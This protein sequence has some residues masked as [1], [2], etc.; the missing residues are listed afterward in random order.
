MLINFHTPSLPPRVTT[1]FGERKG[2]AVQPV[3]NQSLR[4]NH[5][6]NLS[7]HRR[8]GNKHIRHNK[9][10]RHTRPNPRITVRHPTRIIP[11][12][13]PGITTI[14]RNLSLTKNFK[15]LRRNRIDTPSFD[16]HRLVLFSLLFSY[17][18][19]ACLFLVSLPTSPIISSLF[20]PS[21]LSQLLTKFYSCMAFC[22]FTFFLRPLSS[23]LQHLFSGEL[24]Q[25]FF[26]MK[27]SSIS[28]LYK[29]L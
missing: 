29:S 5:H 21:S 9:H 1:L 8:R 11:L 27:P 23:V 6:T 2:T 16:D 25:S 10:Q 20:F 4:K 22:N 7:H 15:G 13:T 24:P 17:P 26:V 19:F 3:P 14:L 28:N 12:V 18:L